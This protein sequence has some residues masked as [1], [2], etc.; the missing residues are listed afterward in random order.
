MKLQSSPQWGSL[1]TLP[2][3][4]Q[5]PMSSCGLPATHVATGRLPHVKQDEAVTSGSQ[6]GSNEGTLSVERSP[7][8]NV[9]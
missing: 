7:F 2:T 5:G 6:A 3:V 9:A 4:R 1:C 8:L